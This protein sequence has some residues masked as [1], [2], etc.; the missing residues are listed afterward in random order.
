VGIK[1]FVRQGFTETGAAE[2]RVI[3]GVMDVLRSLEVNQQPLSF[4]LPLVAQTE[5][6]F[7]RSFEEILGKPFDPRSFRSLRLSLLSDCDAFV[8][9][10]TGLSES[11]AFEVS[12]NCFGGSKVPMFFAIWDQAP[13]KT[14]LLKHLEELAPTKYHTFQEPEELVTPLQEFFA[15][16]AANMQRPKERA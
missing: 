8:V 14:T 5:A 11:T 15:A 10:R 9:I 4:S 1:V 2:Q 7:R 16:V 6:D 13:I 3:N 12:Y